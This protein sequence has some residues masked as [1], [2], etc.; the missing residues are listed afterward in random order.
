[1]KITGT[2]DLGLT[3]PDWNPGDKDRYYAQIICTQGNYIAFGATQADAWADLLNRLN[4]SQ[5][6]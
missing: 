1:M 2:I 5:G 3:G 4:E 6:V